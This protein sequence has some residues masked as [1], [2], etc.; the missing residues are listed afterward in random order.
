[1]RGC[2]NAITA[3]AEIDSINV[4]LENLLLGELTLDAQGHHRFQQFSTDGAAAQR[5]AVA[6]KLLGNAAGAFLGRAAQN[7]ANKS[8]Q[9]PAPINPSVLIETGILARQ[10]RRN[11]KRRDLVERNL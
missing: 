8:P 5:K 7:V 2:L 4:E 3:G 10:D 6:C 9:N 11:K 1:M